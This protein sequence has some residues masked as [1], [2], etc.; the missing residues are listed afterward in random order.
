MLVKFATRRSKNRVI[1]ERKELQIP[2]TDVPGG[3][4]GRSTEPQRH[5]MSE[6]P[7]GTDDAADDDGT[8]STEE[9]DWRQDG[10][11]VYMSD[12]LTKRN[13]T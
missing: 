7:S 1:S 12:D 10:E 3:R 13:A 4:A 9:Y 6:S 8:A 11:K 5:M 2:R